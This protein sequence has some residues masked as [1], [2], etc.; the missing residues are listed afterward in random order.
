MKQRLTSEH[1]KKASL[2]Q[3]QQTTQQAAGKEFSS[4]EE[5]L[6]FDAAQTQVPP[7]VG[8]RLQAA[9]EQEELPRPWWR[10]WLRL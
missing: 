1:D 6:R 7:Q 10:R 9:L 5:M 4:V 3:A 2:D 8:L